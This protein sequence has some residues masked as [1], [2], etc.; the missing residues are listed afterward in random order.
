MYEQYYNFRLK[1]F[2]VPPDPEFLY[3]SEKH[4]KA[5]S[6]LEYGI[7]NKSSISVISGDVGSGKTTIVRELMRKLDSDVVIGMVSNVTINSFKELMQLILYAY[8]LEYRDMTKVEMFEVFT[9]FV[10][11]TYAAQKRTVLILDEA[12][13]LAPEVLEQLRMLSN[14]NVDKHKVFQ[15]ILVGQPNLWDLLRRSDLVQFFQRIEVSYTLSPLDERETEE[16][17]RHRL[18]IAGG[19]KDLFEQDTYFQ[20]WKSTQ[21]S[22]RLINILCG[23]AL[24]Y[25][26]ADQKTSID[27]TTIQQVLEDKRDAMD[28]IRGSIQ[29]DHDTDTVKT[30]NAS[31][32]QINEDSVDKRPNNTNNSVV[33]KSKQKPKRTGLS[34]IE[35]LFK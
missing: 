26:F 28:Q 27:M 5:M 30:N 10:V 12:Q 18:E 16:Y 6:T 31:H 33:N 17:I 15:L 34:S 22:P 29:T 24:V 19:N 21:G 25:G 2:E 8:E 20:I 1:P 14:I 13:N 32:V 4:R 9:E 7:L 35:K 3:M 23:M 11:N